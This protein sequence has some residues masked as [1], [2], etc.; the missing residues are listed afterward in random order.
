MSQVEVEPCMEWLLS[1]LA[2]D[3][4]KAICKK[5]PDY[6]SFQNINVP[7]CSTNENP[8]GMCTPTNGTLSNATT[9]TTTTSGTMVASTSSPIASTAYK[10]GNYSYKLAAWTLQSM[11]QSIP[12][13][14]TQQG[15]MVDANV[16]GDFT[17]NSAVCTLQSM[18][19]TPLKLLPQGWFENCPKDIKA[20][21]HF[22]CL[23]K[24]LKDTDEKC[25][26]WD[27][28]LPLFVYEELF[29]TLNPIPTA[30]TND[31]TPFAKCR[32]NHVKCYHA[33]AASKQQLLLTYNA[34]KVRHESCLV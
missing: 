16:D 17:A 28:S 19:H 34:H 13:P 10:N 31:K 5:F 4:W 33:I 11:K 1:P 22:N 21:P 18:K 27:K 8:T 29:E 7:S 12:I 26:H 2:D 15:L 9:T 3:V 32:R 25:S 20:R 23:L 24:N 14:F 6:S 30:L